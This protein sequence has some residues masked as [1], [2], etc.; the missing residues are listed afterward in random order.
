MRYLGNE[1]CAK[2]I[3]LLMMLKSWL[4]C[5]CVLTATH[6]IRSDVEFS[7]VASRKFSKNGHVLEHLGFL[8]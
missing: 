5:A 4:F 8:D 6:H 7:F 1:G 2:K 3:F